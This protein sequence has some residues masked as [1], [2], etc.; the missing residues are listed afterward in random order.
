[1]LYVSRV[2]LVVGDEPVTA[3]GHRTIEVTVDGHDLTIAVMH[4]AATRVE[5]RLVLL[6]YTNA[7]APLV[8]TSLVEVNEDSKAPLNLEARPGGGDSRATV[9]LTLGGKYR[10]VLPVAANN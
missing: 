9:L 4:L 6:V 7:K 2:T 1:M 8:V 10:A 3:D 5:G